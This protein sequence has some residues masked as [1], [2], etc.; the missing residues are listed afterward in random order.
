ML[1]CAQRNRILSRRLRAGTEFHKFSRQLCDLWS[2]VHL[3]QVLGQSS[4]GLPKLL[5]PQADGANLEK[6]L[7]RVR[8]R[9]PGLLVAA[10]H[11]HH[12]EEVK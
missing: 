8:D 10:K 5:S 6:L 2:E 3:H 9:I 11:D 4:R 7:P 1:S 12:T